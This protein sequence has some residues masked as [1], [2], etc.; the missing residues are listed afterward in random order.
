MDISA[1][2]NYVLALDK[3]GHVWG[4]GSNLTKQIHPSN[5]FVKNALTDIDGEIIRPYKIADLVYF[6]IKF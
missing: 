5:T 3:N 2:S 1:G 6:N 4:W